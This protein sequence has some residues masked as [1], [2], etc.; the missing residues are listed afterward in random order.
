M[1]PPHDYLNSARSVTLFFPSRVRSN[2]V[3]GNPTLFFNEARVFTYS[4]SVVCDLEFAHLFRAARLYR[5]IFLS[6]G[7]TVFLL[8]GARVFEFST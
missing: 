5:A 3:H 7:H 8:S 1:A 2:K 4:T 6:V